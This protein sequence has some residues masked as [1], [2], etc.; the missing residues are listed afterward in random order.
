MVHKMCDYTLLCQKYDEILWWFMD[1]NAQDIVETYVCEHAPD[2]PVWMFDNFI[3]Y[4]DWYRDCSEDDLEY[5]NHYFHVLIVQDIYRHY[6][7][8]ENVYEY[9]DSLYQKDKQHF[10][11][12]EFLEVFGL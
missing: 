12:R 2:T 4:M 9:L 3:K 10:A 8:F 5:R 1:S 7:L 11:D 6:E